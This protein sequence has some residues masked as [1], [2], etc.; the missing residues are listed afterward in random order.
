MDEQGTNDDILI[1]DHAL[2]CNTEPGGESAFEFEA[3]VLLLINALAPEPAVKKID[4]G[5]RISR[6]DLCE[7]RSESKR[8]N[9]S[10]WN[11]V[12]PAK[13]GTGLVREPSYLPV[14]PPLVREKASNIGTSDEIAQPISRDAGA[15]DLG[16]LLAEARAFAT[17][18]CVMNARTRKALYAALGRTYDLTFYA[19]SQ[20][21]AYTRLIEEAGLTIQDRAPYTPIIKLVFGPDYDKTRVAEFAAAIVYGRGKSL[22]VGSFSGFLE[23]FDGGLKAVVSLERLMRHG[24]DRTTT[25]S[26]RNEARPAIAYKLRKISLQTWSDLSS[27]GDEFALLMARRLPDGGV[28]MV[29]EVPRDIALLEKAARKLLANLGRAAEDKAASQKNYTEVV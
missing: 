12:Q 27:E 29:G 21:E 5:R 28:A 11:I 15:M 3:D 23:D 19:D 25:G 1:L 16:H 6:F 13:P 4:V 22:S 9:A 20:P 7:A 8:R 26:A 14:R 24:E 17:D 2:I 10:G 18:Y